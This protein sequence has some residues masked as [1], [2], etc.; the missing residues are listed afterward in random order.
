[1]SRLLVFPARVGMAALLLLSAGLAKADATLKWTG[2]PG[3]VLKY[4]FTQLNDIKFTVQGQQ[5]SSKSE[6][7]V[8][9]KWTI[10]SVALDGMLDVTQV[11][12]RVRVKI[13]TA[14]RIISYD[15]SDKTAAG[16]PEVQMFSKIYDA[17]L[18]QAY[19]LKISPQGEMVD[20]KVP[21]VVIAAVGGSPFAATADSGSFLTPA[22]VKNMFAQIMPKLPK[23][24]VADGASWKTDL[25]LPTGPITM[26]LQN[27]Y[28]LGES[29]P[30]AKFQ[31][32][33][34]TSIKAGAEAAVTFKLNK[35][36]GSGKFTFDTQAGR[37][38]ESSI[39]QSFDMTITANGMD[40]P[41]SIVLSANLKL[42]K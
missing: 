27:T 24:A 32:K 11:A 13:T 36:S 39:D 16:G 23:D 14:G 7:T 3:E 8:D 41:Q 6:L 42:V 34:D 5:T 31:A 29:T 15:S 26:V 20:V 1:M 17:M 12:D 22:G 37:L 10:K 28:T 18:G 30:F 38:T 9:L 33:I 2:K 19:T 35:Q 25:T 21:D 40:I 4:S